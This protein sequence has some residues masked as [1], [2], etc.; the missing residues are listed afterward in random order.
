MDS[1]LSTFSPHKKEKAFVEL[2]HFFMCKDNCQ[3]ITP[4]QN[5][6]GRIIWAQN[7]DS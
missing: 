1:L 3:D 6:D 7:S 4:L 2:F 5:I